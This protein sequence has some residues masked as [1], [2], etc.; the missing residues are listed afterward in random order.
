[1]RANEYRDQ[2]ALELNW[3]SFVSL[4]AMINRKMLAVRKSATK[5][6]LEYL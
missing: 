3:R 2:I 6:V 5:R 4:R 1:V